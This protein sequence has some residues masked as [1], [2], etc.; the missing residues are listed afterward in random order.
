MTQSEILKTLL[1]RNKKKY[2][3]KKYLEQYIVENFKY[4]SLIN[5][6][7]KCFSYKVDSIKITVF[8]FPIPDVLDENLSEVFR[9]VI[10]Y[11]AD[12]YKKGEFK[13]SENELKKHLLQII[14]ND[15][16]N[17]FLTTSKK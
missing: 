14:D 15:I 7:L 3:D 10:L 16:F 8:Y 17:I 9:Y 1:E 5:M 12:F 2:E 11:P 13:G 6:L 4:N